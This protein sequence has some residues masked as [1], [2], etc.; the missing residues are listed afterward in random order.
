VADF[1]ALLQLG[2]MGVMAFAAIAV[3]RIV[4]PVLQALSDRLLD[5][6]ERQ[7]QA[8]DRLGDIAASMDKRLII[9]EQQIDMLQDLIHGVI[10]PYQAGQPRASQRKRQAGTGLLDIPTDE[11]RPTNRSVSGRP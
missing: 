1:T 9:V 11:K 3:T 6:V 5:A 10:W 2:G 7:S 4:L 8:I